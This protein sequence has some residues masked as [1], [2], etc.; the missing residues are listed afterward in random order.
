M[1]LK[2]KL[3]F[4]G[5]MELLFNNDKFVE[6]KIPAFIN[7]PNPTNMQDLIFWIRDNLLKERPGLFISENTVRPGILV[8]INETDWELEGELDYEIKDGDDIVFI[9]TLHGG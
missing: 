9:S 2:V 7:P 5:G 4:S 1:S 6:V 8:L 3:S